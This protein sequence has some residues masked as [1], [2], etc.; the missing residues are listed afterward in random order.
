[1]RKLFLLILIPLLFLTTKG[2][3][4]VELDSVSD[5]TYSLIKLSEVSS[6]GLFNLNPTSLSFSFNV[7]DLDFNRDYG[8]LVLFPMNILDF[9]GFVSQNGPNPIITRISF[10]IYEYF[11]NDDP[12]YQPDIYYNRTLQHDNFYQVD[13]NP[14]YSDFIA[15]SLNVLH[16]SV[17]QNVSLSITLQGSDIT[18][19]MGT[20]IPDEFFNNAFVFFNKNDINEF[21]DSGFILNWLLTNQE[22]VAE[23]IG[24]ESGFNAGYDKGYNEAKDSYAYVDNGEYYTGN[25]A[26]NKGYNDGVDTDVKAEIINFVPGVLGAIFMFF[27]QLGQIGIL[28]ITILDVLGLLVLISALIFV[29]KFFF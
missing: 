3:Y 29:I 22:K 6:G 13:L 24:R 12:Y 2:I 8:T 5:D 23:S 25:Y 9:R 26:Y 16:P 10:T 20:Y 14:V 15:L 19:V 18:T 27:F 4:A 28:G 17:S 11:S 7:K 21:Y 1:M